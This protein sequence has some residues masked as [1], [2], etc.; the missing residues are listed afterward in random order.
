MYNK[1]NFTLDHFKETTSEKICFFF[2]KSTPMIKASEEKVPFTDL[3]KP[4]L[5]SQKSTRH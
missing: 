2:L 1:K 5:R 3:I 4:S